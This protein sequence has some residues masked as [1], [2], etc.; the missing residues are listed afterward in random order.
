MAAVSNDVQKSTRGK[1]RRFTSHSGYGKKI[2]KPVLGVRYTAPTSRFYKSSTKR[3]WCIEECTIMI[4][5]LYQY[6]QCRFDSSAQWILSH[7]LPC[8]RHRKL[9]LGWNIYSRNTPV[10]YGRRSEY[11][12]KALR[13]AAI[14]AMCPTSA[15][16]TSTYLV[17]V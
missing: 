12:V 2:R 15:K 7:N 6:Y 4:R 14:P 16:T 10:I 3:I 5:F 11:C 1:C 8:D 13:F 9:I 17:T